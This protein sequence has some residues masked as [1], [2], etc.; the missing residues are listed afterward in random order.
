MTI[1]ERFHSDVL[2][3]F[4]TASTTKLRYYVIFVDYF[5]ESVGCRSCRR[6]IR[7]YQNFGEFKALVEKD[8][9]K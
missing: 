8:I 9:G 6:K 2:G 3:P 5:L 4:S 7:C 1:L